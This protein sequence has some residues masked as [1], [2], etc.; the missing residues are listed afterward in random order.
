MDA[1][2]GEALF[3]L[4]VLTA[5]VVAGI[6]VHRAAF[7]SRPNKYAAPPRSETEDTALDGLSTNVPDDV[8]DGV[9]DSWSDSSSES[10]SESS[11]DASSD[12]GTNHD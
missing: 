1:T 4:G 12:S 9:S 3:V 10:S 2:N 6:L 11:S 7:T 8:F 5:A